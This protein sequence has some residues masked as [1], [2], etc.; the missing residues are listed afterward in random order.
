[1]AEAKAWIVHLDGRPCVA[2][3]EHEMVHFV[4]HPVCEDIPHTPMHCHQVLWWEGEFLPVLDLAAWLTGRPVPVPML[5]LA[6]CAGRNGQ[7]R[8][9]NTE[10]CCARAYPRSSRSKTSRSVTCLWSQPAGE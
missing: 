5:Q 7:R 6:L 8:P 2:M 1:M 10:P 9:H 3:G 4:E